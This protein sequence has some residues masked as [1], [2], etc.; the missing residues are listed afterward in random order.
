MP[1]T[2]R[3]DDPESKKF[4]EFVE[5]TAREVREER[6][7]WAQRDDKDQQSGTDS[8]RRCTEPTGRHQRDRVR[9]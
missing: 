7:S 4:W 3:R 9:T 6:P 5:Q 8:N 1:L 2:P